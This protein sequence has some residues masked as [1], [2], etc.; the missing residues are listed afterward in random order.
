MDKTKYSNIIK[1]LDDT[2]EKIQDAKVD[3]ITGWVYKSLERGHKPT[4][5]LVSFNL[6]HA[7]RVNTLKN[8]FDIDIP[9][10]I[11]HM[12]DGEP[13][14]LILDYCESPTLLNENGIVGDR[15][16]FGVPSEQLKK[17][18]IAICD[19]LHSKDMWLELSSEIDAACLLINATMAMNQMERNWIKE[20]AAP[21][22]GDKDITVVITKMAQLNEE[23]DV[24]AVCQVV[25]NSLERLNVSYKT[26]E[27]ERETLE[28][29]NGQLIREYDR[30]TRDKRVI[31]NG[32]RA[33]TEH[34]KYLIDSVVIDSATIQGTIEQLEK[35]QKSLELAGQLA[36]E[37]ILC[38]ALNQLK[39]KICDGIRDYGRQMAANIKKKIEVSPLDQL[40]TMDDKINGYV[41]GSWEYYIK[42]MSKKADEE[43]EAIA[44]R[45]AKQMEL[46][47]GKMISDLDESARRTVY[48]ALGLTT[49]AATGTA[50]IDPRSIVQKNGSLSEISVG[51]VTDQL[52]KETRNMMLLSIPLF[53]VNPWVS[54]GNIFA[55]KIYGKYKTNSELSDVRS[56]MAKQVEQSCFDNAEAIVQ[57]VT[58]SF[59]DEIRTGSINIKSAY[60]GLIRQIEDSLSELKVSQGERAELKNYLSNLVNVEFPSILSNL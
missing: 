13:A 55:A 25:R 12:I 59:D 40:E 7:D 57:Q 52:R 42:S 17:G 1:M 27:D 47:A 15:I 46:D 29:V 14:C 24:Q 53:F 21:F 38:N 3:E 18:R 10:D 41:S 54:V 20:C 16:T 32:I 9:K 60:N 19:E 23:E 4:L 39:S 45:L 49:N 44:Q 33:I 43:V 6:N 26:Y 58:L 56:E 28:Q 48:S 5:A 37:S 34:L 2:A 50:L 35:Q 36:A 30:E 22:Y 8:V 51:T 11:V 31:K